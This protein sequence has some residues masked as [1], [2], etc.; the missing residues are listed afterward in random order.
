M[1]KIIVKT[2]NFAKR[3]IK[4]GERAKRR[5]LFGMAAATR[6]ELR[7]V[8]KR[9]RKGP[10]KADGKSAPH[11]HGTYRNTALFRVDSN[12]R[13]YSA[14]FA[15]FRSSNKNL[16]LAG[17]TALAQ[18]NLEFGATIRKKPL[19]RQKSTFPDRLKG[20]YFKRKIKKTQIRN[21]FEI[22]PRPHVFVARE[23]LFKGSS[24]NQRRFLA[25]Q[26]YLIDRGYL[27]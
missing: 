8:V 25:A 13:G 6:N 27:K 24:K 9:K 5:A 10:S 16:V 11:D 17:S 23:R 14:G 2:D 15:D 20:K 18:D 21:S 19:R 22:K 12:S 4:N 7:N 1:A 26:Q 3:I